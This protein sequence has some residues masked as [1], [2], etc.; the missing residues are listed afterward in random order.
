[1][2]LHHASALA[3]LLAAALLGCGTSTTVPPHDAYAPA[4]DWGT[5]PLKDAE[6]EAQAQ[7]L[8]VG[9]AACWLG[10]L[11]SDAAGDPQDE[12]ARPKAIVNRCDAVLEHVY[13]SVDPVRYEQL[14]AVEPRVVDDIAARV[15]AVA[16]GDRVDHGHGRALASLLHAVADAQRENV[17][18]RQLVNDVRKSEAERGPSHAAERAEDKRYAAHALLQT[19]GLERLLRMNAGDLSH[20][21]R[22]FGLLCTLDRMAMARGLPKHL[23]VYAVG[24]P[25]SILFGVAPPAVPRDPAAPIKT[26]TWPTFLADVAAAAGHPVPAEATAPIDHES[27]AWSGVLAG[28]SDRLRPEAGAVSDRTPLPKVLSVVVA[29]LDTQDRTMHALFAAERRGERAGGP[30]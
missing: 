7:R 24:A 3:L 20:E 14:R 2:R 1:M 11:W 27:L 13:G 10:G 18:A 25:L 26:G 9:T 4:R 23:K 28:L 21:A 29:R 5:A 17:V 15:E 6:T 12:D 22:A 19:Q 16:D 8:V 30:R